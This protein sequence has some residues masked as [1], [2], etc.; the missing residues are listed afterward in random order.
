MELEGG[1]V[2]IGVVVEGGVVEVVVSWIEDC[3]EVTSVRVRV[4]DVEKNVELEVGN[5][6]EEEEEEL[7][8]VVALLIELLLVLLE[9]KENR[10]DRDELRMMDDVA[11]DEKEVD[12]EL[13]L[14]SELD[15]EEDDEE[16]VEEVDDDELSIVASSQLLDSKEC[17]DRERLSADVTLE[18]LDMVEDSW[19][20]VVDGEVVLVEDVVIEAD[21]VFLSEE[22]ELRSKLVTNR[23]CEKDSRIEFSRYEDSRYEFS[24]N[25]ISRNESRR[26]DSED[27]F[28]SDALFR[29]RSS[30]SG[31]DDSE[32]RELERERI[33]GC[34][35]ESELPSVRLLLSPK[36]GATSDLGR[37]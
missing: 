5:V 25:D 35:Y 11:D 19:V 16:V 17:S 9:E 18:L 7:E 3:E 34:R 21:E 26:G 8:D 10:L 2:M 31:K 29:C 12:S 28:E 15:S 23:T 1:V 33:R 37:S 24:R 4:V 6:D 13:E 27:R 30:R 22:N 36:V 20:A 32:S 14:D